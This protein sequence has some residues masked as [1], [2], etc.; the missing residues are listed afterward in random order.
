[1]REIKFRAWHRDNKC[2]LDSIC[3]YSD[4]SWS[5]SLVGE[6]GEV[7]GYDERECELMQYTG[8]KDKNGKE[9]YEGD[10]L[11]TSTSNEQVMWDSKDGLWCFNERCPVYFADINQREVIG[12]IWENRDM[13]K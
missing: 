1:M 3:V 4:G 13:L 9:I 12:N 8:L 7:S 5:G 6:R 2:W 10:I 11:K